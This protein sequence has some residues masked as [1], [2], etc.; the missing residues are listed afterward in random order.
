[1]T[2][3]RIIGHMVTRN[4]MG[5][6][7]PITLKWLSKITD[8]VYVH[9]D[10]ST[11]G[12]FEHVWTRVP[13]DKRAPDDVSFAEDEGLFRGAAWRRME[14]FFAPTERDWILCIDADELLLSTLPLSDTRAALVS[15]VQTAMIVGANAITF[16]I[17][18]TFDLAEGV[19]QIRTDGYWGKVRACRW[20]RWRPNGRFSAGEACGSVPRS[21]TSDDYVSLDLA[22]LHLGYLRREDRIAKY[23]RYSAGTGH[24]PRHVASILTPALLQPWA[25]QLVPTGI[26]T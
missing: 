4:E 20:V 24:N 2:D 6:Y 25:G 19:P 11:D 15:E 9:D 7:L 23:Q 10:R 21:W 17:A 13:S 3:T 12:T 5:R 14:L 18:E 22:I 26:T 16:D 8:E 1:M